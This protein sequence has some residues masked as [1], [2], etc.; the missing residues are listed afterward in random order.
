MSLCMA[1]IDFKGFLPL[2]LVMAALP[3]P[4]LMR[5]EKQWSLRVEH[6]NVMFFLRPLPIVPYERI[7]SFR[8]TLETDFVSTFS[9][10]V[11]DSC[12]AR[13]YRVARSLVYRSDG[14]DG[15]RRHTNH[16]WRDNCSP[17][18]DSCPP[19]SLGY[20]ALHSSRCGAGQISSDCPP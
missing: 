7:F 11:S 10:V 8:S 2:S 12:N 14:D 9:V 6:M 5:F 18:F 13:S 1:V 17:L 4:T 19:L 3:F 16:S 20:S 15:M